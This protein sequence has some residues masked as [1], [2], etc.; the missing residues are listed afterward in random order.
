MRQ[1]LAVAASER[2]QDQQKRLLEYFR[3]FDRELNRLRAAVAQANKPLPEDPQL[4]ALQNAVAEAKQPIQVDP[5]L[6]RLRNEVTVSGGQLKHRRLTAAQ[7]LAWAL[8][9]NAAFLFN[10]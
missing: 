6:V 2:N 5:A 3:K 7:D 10:H 9:N 1:V 8:I 4:V